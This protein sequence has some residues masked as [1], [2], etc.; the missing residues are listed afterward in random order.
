M[1]RLEGHSN[2]VWSVVFS[3]D[4]KHIASG[5]GDNTIQIWNA[6]TGQNVMEPLKGH[7][8]WVCSV[9]FSPD[10]KYIASGSD[11]NTIRV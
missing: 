10:S 9:A 7:S 11:D 5:S 3:P 8:N 1:G 4:G 2:S 6:E